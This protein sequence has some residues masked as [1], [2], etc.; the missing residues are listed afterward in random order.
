[1]TKEATFNNRL[2]HEKSPYLL[3]HAHNPVDWFPWGEEAF[4]KAKKENKPIFLSIGYSTCHW[5]HVMERESFEDPTIAKIINEYFIPI[6]V[7]REERPDIDHVYM[8][9]VTAMTGQGG[10]P[11]TAFITADKKPFYGGTY[12]PPYAKWGSPGL[13]DLMNSIHKMWQTNQ[14]KVIESS[15]S[16]TEL[17]QSKESSQG[18]ADQ[19]T[20]N[21]LTRAFD[22][23]GQM[24]DRLYGGFGSSPKFPTSHNLSL[25]L[26]YWKRFSDS[27]ALEMVEFTLTK[28]AQGG[29]YD[30]LGGGFHR[31]ST[32]QYW[33]VPHFEKMLYDQAILAT[34]Y[35]EAYQITKKEYYAEIARAIFDYVLR[36]MQFPE[37]GFYC[38]EDADSFDPEEYKEDNPQAKKHLEKK[39]GA[40]Y[41]WKYDEIKDLL[42]QDSAV[43][44]YHFGIKE[45]GNAK[46]DPHGEF[47]AKNIIYVEHTL[48]ETAE[49]FKKSPEEINAIIQKSKEKLFKRRGYRPRPHLDD[50]ILVDWNG[51]MIASLAFGSSVL[52]EPKYKEAATRATQFI[53]KKLMTKDGRLLHRYRDGESAIPATVNDY[54]FFVHGLLNLYEATFDVQYLQLAQDLTKKMTAL[55]WDKHSGGFYMTAH[56]GEELLFK[57]KEIYDGA[58]PSANSIAALN[59]VRLFHI[60]LEKEGEANLQQ[61]FKFFA[62]EVG[63]HPSA[64]AQMLIAF[65]FALGPS[66]EIV[67]A[68]TKEDPTIQNMVELIYDRFIPNKVLILHTSLDKTKIDPVILIS[69]FVKAQVPISGS[70]TAYVCQNHVCKLPVTQLNDLKKLLDELK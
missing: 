47:I 26:R 5:C 1:M 38:A 54:A 14:A 50:K 28:M 15:V 4:A 11:L 35:L 69:P 16:L 45:N 67:L 17:L 34:T 19:L 40:F 43:F 60:T 32:D 56:D 42:G 48:E 2:I 20:K 6:K 37:G 3:Q 51:L 8:S 22:E 63:Q 64:Y 18:K 21:I 25:L 46:V 36:D 52:H 62:N 33:Q 65:D 61:L 53:L 30:H 55:F 41:V 29:M 39:E 70:A 27:K 13:V 7:D 57:Q 9:A 31:Y 44:N 12:F 23:Y 66:T 24:Y 59:L 49:Q 10:W 68:G 58:I